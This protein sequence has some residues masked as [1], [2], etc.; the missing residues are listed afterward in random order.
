VACGFATVTWRNVGHGSFHVPGRRDVLHSDWRQKRVGHLLHVTT[1]LVDFFLD[2]KETIDVGAA[3]YRQ[4]GTE[5]IQP[6]DHVDVAI[7][8]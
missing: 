5:L 6:V 7:L 4:V 2:A 1:K 3:W 8:A